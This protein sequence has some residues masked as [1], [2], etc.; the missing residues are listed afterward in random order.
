MDLLA[1]PGRLGSARKA[2]ANKSTG[3]FTIRLKDTFHDSYVETCGEATTRRYN[4]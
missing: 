4:G 3:S 2:L 1:Q